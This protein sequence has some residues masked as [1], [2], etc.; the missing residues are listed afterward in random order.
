[1][2]NLNLNPLA[3]KFIFLQNLSLLNIFQINNIFNNKGS[4]HDLVLSNSSSPIVPVYNDFI[5]P[6]DFYH[7]SLYLDYYFLNVSSPL[8]F[9]EL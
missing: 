7:P 1:M 3:L 6:I 9:S 4:M 2:S 8:T 5:V